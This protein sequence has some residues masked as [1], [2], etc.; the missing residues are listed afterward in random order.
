MYKNFGR[1]VFICGLLISPNALADMQSEIDHLLNYVKSTNCQY[2]RNGDLH[3]GAEAAQHIKKKYQYY[4]DDIET[5]EDFIRLSAT[6]ST[7][8]KKRYRILCA[9]QPKV[10]SNDWL[11]A[12]LERYRSKR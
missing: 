9:G 6:Q 11:L 4:E 10:Y 3:S 8:S 12:E 5:T 1:F 2:E 7:M